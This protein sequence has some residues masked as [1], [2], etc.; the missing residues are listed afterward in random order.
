MYEAP[1]NQKLLDFEAK[2]RQKF[3]AT[4]EELPMDT[5]EMKSP[6]R[7]GVWKVKKGGAPKKK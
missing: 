1:P 7:K 5:E 4:M 3:D 2:Q 6:V